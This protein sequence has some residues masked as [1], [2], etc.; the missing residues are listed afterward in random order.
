[1]LTFLFHVAIKAGREE[2]WRTLATRLT[3]AARTEDDGCLTYT[4]F[5]Q[6]DQPRAYVLFEQWRDSTALR[7]RLPVPCSECRWRSTWARP[8]S[9]GSG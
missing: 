5:Q 6:A 2:E 4:F 7:R 1:M 9:S 8:I 3:T